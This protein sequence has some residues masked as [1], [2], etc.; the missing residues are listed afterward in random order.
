MAHRRQRS[1]LPLSVDVNVTSLVDVAFTLLVIF[2]ITAPA[3]HGG[4]EVNLPDADAAPLSIADPL[5]ITLTRAGEVVV[6]GTAL[7]L[8]GLEESIARLLQQDQQAIVR[9]DESVPTGATVRVLA[10]IEAAGGRP[11]LATEPLI[12]VR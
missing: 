7:A 8:E 2:I 3:L 11:S 4:I 9:A 10:A 5:V 12:E 1:E 6:S